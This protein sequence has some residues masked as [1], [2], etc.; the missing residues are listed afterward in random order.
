MIEPILEF[1][2]GINNGFKQI[3]EAHNLV[4]QVAGLSPIPNPQ[5]GIGHALDGLGKG[6]D[7]IK[8]NL[9]RGCRD[10]GINAEACQDIVDIMGVGGAALNGLANVL[11]AKKLAGLA[12]GAK[13][14]NDL[15][16]KQAVSREALDLAKAQNAIKADQ[17]KAVMGREAPAPKP[18]PRAAKANPKPAPKQTAAAQKG[19]G[20]GTPPQKMAPPAAKQTA[21]Q[22]PAK[23]A[24]VEKKTPAA[25][26][27]TEQKETGVHKNSNSYV[28]DTHVYSIQKVSDGKTY[29]VGESAQGYRKKDGASK[30]AEQQVR[31]LQQETGDLYQSKVRKE[32]D[33]KKDAREYETT[34][35][36]KTRE[37]KGKD[38]LPGNKGNH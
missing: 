24:A 21:N 5:E 23:P 12:N 34:L 11:R 35:I 6:H 38:A 27:K 2:A 1:Q 19:R 32:F 31:K 9:R 26:K 3:H 25:V 36:K 18:T 15:V 10:N 16:P 28:G 29:K 14:G 30:R 8:A 33:T 17:L 7:Q 13:R 37:L 4:R 22:N 20:E